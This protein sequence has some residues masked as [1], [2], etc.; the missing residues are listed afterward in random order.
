MHQLQHSCGGV[1]LPWP[2]AVTVTA[3]NYLVLDNSDYLV[4]SLPSEYPLY[5]FPPSPPLTPYS[6]EQ[7]SIFILI[8]L[9]SHVM[10]LSTAVL[11]TLIPAFA[12]SMVLKPRQTDSVPPS[13]RNC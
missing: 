1:C 11:A 3:F 9:T 13:H 5:I 4:G 12:A 2:I 7:P 8:H 10:R 6:K